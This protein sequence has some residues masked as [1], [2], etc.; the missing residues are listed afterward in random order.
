ML[1]WSVFGLGYGAHL[2]WQS[3]STW[4]WKALGLAIVALGMVLC[5][6][7][8]LAAGVPLVEGLLPAYRPGL[9]AAG[10]LVAAAAFQ[11][12]SMPLRYAMLTTKRIW[13]MLAVT[14]VAATLALAGGIGVLYGSQDRLGADL[15]RISWTSGGAAA[16][17]LMATLA[18][19]SG[20]RR[21]LWGT[22]ARV[23]LITVYLAAGLWLLQT[24]R[25]HGWWPAALAAV[26][27]VV[28]AWRLGMLVDWRNLLRSSDRD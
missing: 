14:G 15:I 23:V 10:G 8:L 17:L 12:I 28:P 13:P 7:A 6:A 4:L 2:L 1:G 27:C 19:C 5:A 9:V 26:W 22:A 11:G 25:G 3:S 21:E 20:R 24:L 18:L 16:F